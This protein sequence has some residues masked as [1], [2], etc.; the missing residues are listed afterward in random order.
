MKH[1]K[2]QQKQRYLLNNH[3]TVSSTSQSVHQAIAPVLQH[4]LSSFHLLSSMMNHT[5]VSNESKQNSM[6]ADLNGIVVVN[7]HSHDVHEVS[8]H[9]L[10]RYSII[11]W[12]C[13]RRYGMYILAASLLDS[14]RMSL[15][16][17]I[18]FSQPDVWVTA[19]RWAFCNC[20][21]I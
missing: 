16:E 1:K 12:Q 17:G 4:S 3:I 21:K 2:H 15:I 6:Q 5:S 14:L 8:L 11:S 10:N 20:C 7:F 18:W 9:S 19:Q 13:D